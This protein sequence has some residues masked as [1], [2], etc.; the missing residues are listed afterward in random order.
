MSCGYAAVA[1]GVCL[2]QV[3]SN[4]VEKKDSVPAPNVA[5]EGLHCIA[6]PERLPLLH[7]SV[8]NSSAPH[9]RACIC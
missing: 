9:E 1:A 7:P 8:S 6:Y 4:N 5:W 2:D 3:D